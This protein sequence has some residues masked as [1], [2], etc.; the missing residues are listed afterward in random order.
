M[1]SETSNQPTDMTSGPLTP[2][3]M[4]LL[5]R[6]SLLHLA[7]C[8]DN[9]PHVSLMNYTFIEP[10]EDDSSNNISLLKNSRNLI[11]VA[12]PK[13]TQKFENLQKN[14]K[15]SI[16]IHDWVTNSNQANDNNVLKLLYSI[17][18]SEVGDLSVTLDGHVVKFLLDSKSD[19]YEFFKNLHLKKNP[20]AKAFI[21]GDN[22]ALILI[23][24]DESKVSDTNNKVEKF[25]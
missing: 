15:C 4:N 14:G 25:K 18:Q 23:Q 11:L 19:E 1:T 16:L 10:N 2:S 20:F 7:T 9:V 6:S 21:E 5:S 13:N 3:V 12:T 22:V 17:N 8:A 24:I